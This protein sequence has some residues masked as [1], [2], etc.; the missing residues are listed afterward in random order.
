MSTM[1]HTAG[2]RRRFR[3]TP[4]AGSVCAEVEDDFHHMRVS[5]KHDGV[6]A[7]TVTASLLRAPWSTCPG[8][9][10]KCEETFTGVELAAFPALRDKT[11]N[12]THLYDLALLAAAHAH[13]NVV[14][15]YDIYVSDP[16]DGKRHAQL[17]RNAE[18]IIEWWDKSYRIVE[19]GELAGMKLNDMRL[20]IDSL[21]PVQQEAAR[22]L[23]WASIIAHGRIIPMDKQSDASR[24]PPSC[25]TFQPERAVIARRIG[26]TR[27]FSDATAQPLE[28]PEETA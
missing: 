9:Q 6:T 19:P 18:H 10:T 4:Q 3:V 28:F 1:Q 23:Q 26:Q 16:I 17:W 5:I 20:W 8:A 2:F 14:L 27:D 25:Y 7:H 15:V 22:I 13:E 11:Y 12:C 24:M 21:A